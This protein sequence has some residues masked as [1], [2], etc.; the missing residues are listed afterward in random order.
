M[1]AETLVSLAV[2][3][4]WRHVYRM[5]NHP[6]SIV[7]VHGLVHPKPLVRLVRA[8]PARLNRSERTVATNLEAVHPWRAVR[9]ACVNRGGACSDNEA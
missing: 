8:A 3:A 2:R 4:V 1:G 9:A 6:F 5:K 7:P